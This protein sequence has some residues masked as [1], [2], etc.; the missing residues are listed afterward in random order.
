VNEE[1]TPLYNDLQNE[2]QIVLN[3]LFGDP[4]TFYFDI[5]LENLENFGMFCVMNDDYS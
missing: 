1:V 2:V 4:D 5:F 3:L